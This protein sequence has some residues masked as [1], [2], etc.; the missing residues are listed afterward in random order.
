MSLNDFDR[1]LYAGLKWI[2][3]LVIERRLSLRP[4]S[5]FETEIALLAGVMNPELVQIGM[6]DIIPI[7][8]DPSL[9]HACE[10]LGLRF[11][12]LTALALGS[13]VFIRHDA[14]SPVL[15]K[16]EMRLVY[17]FEVAG[18]LEAYFRIYLNEL[19]SFGYGRMPMELEAA[20]IAAGT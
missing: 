15:L 20:K 4:L 5:N 9:L 10:I 3:E 2:D 12:E 1:L 14:A 8:T 13:T 11:E 7:P 6:V 19:I 16:H 17:H 18:S